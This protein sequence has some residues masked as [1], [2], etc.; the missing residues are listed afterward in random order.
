M[1]AQTVD[2]VG[3]GLGHGATLHRDDVVVAYQKPKGTASASN[4]GQLVV[5]RSKP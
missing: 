1:L 2:F 5:G 4:P 3:A